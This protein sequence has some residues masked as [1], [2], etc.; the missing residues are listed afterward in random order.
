MTPFLDLRTIAIDPALAQQLPVGLAQY[1]EAVPIAHHGKRVTVAMSH[2][3]NTTALTVLKQVL[4]ANVV[5]I[6]TDGAA[7]RAALREV[8]THPPTAHGVLAWLSSS[9]EQAWREYLRA[10]VDAP[11][12][13][14]DP[15]Q[16]DC[17]TLI[18][19]ANRTAP[20]LVVSCTASAEVRD[21]MLGKIHAPIWFAPPRPKSPAK[22]L[23]A[24]RGFASDEVGLAWV[25][26]LAAVQQ[27]PSVTL[28]PILEQGAW[29]GLSYL[30]QPSAV[31]SYVARCVE[32]LGAMEIEPMLTMQ[33]G[34]PN[35]Q[36]V[37]A[38]H[39]GEHDLMVIAAE[40]H[41]EFVGQLLEELSQAKRWPP[42]GVIV[43]KAN[44]EPTPDKG[45]N[46][47]HVSNSHPLD[48]Q[49]RSPR[50]IRRRDES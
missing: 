29:G 8:Y 1:Y 4:R 17:T 22:I 3:E 46:E 49:R 7:V 13:V 9:L 50:R 36:V 25:M 27:Q 10:M 42:A 15:E 32:Q 41:G 19:V 44:H 24:L 37:R 12:T 28:M 43:V 34:P 48:R 11:L 45:G 2:P 39:S 16:V 38:M 47:R 30:Q 20:E 18:E 31:Q 5:A 35:Q 6:R 23:L 40:G 33:S 14:L 26:R 21:A